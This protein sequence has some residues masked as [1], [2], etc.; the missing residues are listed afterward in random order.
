MHKL[1]PQVA[2]AK[3]IF[4]GL[5]QSESNYIQ[6][7]KNAIKNYLIPLRTKATESGELQDVITI[8]SNIE[9]IVDIHTDIYNGMVNL[10]EESWPIIDGLGLLFLKNAS[11]FQH[12]GDFAENFGM[13]QLTLAKILGQKKNR[14]R[15]VLEVNLHFYLI[16]II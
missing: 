12:Y 8:F 13:S 2:D 1:V 10:Q 9:T 5:L 16:L 14:L 4:I 6:N 11:A 3:K 7:L 15:E